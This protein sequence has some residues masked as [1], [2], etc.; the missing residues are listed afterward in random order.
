MPVLVEQFVVVGD[1][2]EARRAAEL[3]R[4]LPKGFK[5]YYNVPDSAKI[6]QFAEQQ[7]PLQQIVGEWPAGT[8]PAVHPRCGDRKIVR[9]RRDHR[10]CSFGSGGSE[11]GHRLLRALRP[12]QAGQ[13]LVAASPSITCRKASSSRPG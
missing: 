9:E 5:T 13:S 11:K 2:G 7:I 6:Q 8:D 10:Q 3:W 4:F 12:A 1:A